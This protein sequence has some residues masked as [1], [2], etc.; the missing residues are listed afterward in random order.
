LEH[1]HSQ[2]N[3]R[4]EKDL[5]NPSDSEPFVKEVSNEWMSKRH[6]Q[7]PSIS[8]AERNTQLSIRDGHCDQSPA[9]QIQIERTSTAE[10]RKKLL[11]FALQATRTNS[12][13]ITIKSLHLF[14]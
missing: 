2:D 11:L 9:L 7:V 8:T 12:Q 3:Q 13:T 5:A 4:G 1:H 10:Q 14:W 6:Y